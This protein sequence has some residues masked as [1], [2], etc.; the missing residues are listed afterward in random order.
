MEVFF[1]IL[2]ILM[3]FV[4]VFMVYVEMKVSIHLSKNKNLKEKFLYGDILGKI[5]YYFKYI[6]Q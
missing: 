1:I 4:F 6:L 5:T 2:S 3:L